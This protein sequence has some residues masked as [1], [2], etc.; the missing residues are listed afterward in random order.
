VSS[1]S[2]SE[3]GNDEVEGVKVVVDR[4]VNRD[5]LV[6]G[7]LRVEAEVVLERLEAPEILEA[8]WLF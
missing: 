5:S 1:A 3:A 7:F 2:L 8:D 6:D 4:P